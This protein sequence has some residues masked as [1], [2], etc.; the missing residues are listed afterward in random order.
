MKEN[1]DSSPGP[2]HSGNETRDDQSASQP[3]QAVGPY[4]GAEPSAPASKVDFWV[5][6]N[7]LVRRWG[8]LILGGLVGASGFFYLAQR[9]V[10]PK[11]TASAQ[12]IRS[13][14]LLRRVG[15]Q[16]K[17]PIPPETL[18]KCIKVEPEADSDMV[19]ILLAA[20]RPEQ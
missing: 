12:L 3:T 13:P 9:V 4:L 16:A 17:P 2:A 5:A 10:L 15:D 20:R 19:K 7:L 11:F 6:A 14:E 1:F 8:W 18:F